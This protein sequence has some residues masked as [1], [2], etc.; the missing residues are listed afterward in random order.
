MQKEMIAWKQDLAILPKL[1]A[2]NAE[3]KA[4]LQ[5]A[6]DEI[7]SLTKNTISSVTPN[8]PQRQPQQPQQPQPPQT[9]Q[10]Q[11]QQQQHALMNIKH[12]QEQQ[13]KQYN[14]RTRE[15]VTFKVGDLVMRK[16]HAK[17]GSFPKERWTGPWKILE[18]KNKEGS[19]YKLARQA[20]P[21]R[22]TMA[23]IAVL[24][25]F[26]ERE[27]DVVPPKPSQFQSLEEAKDT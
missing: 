7:K 4:Q 2:E 15:I 9:P 18:V 23:N 6:R 13:E 3:L 20:T 16:N 24:R 14:K 1:R 22:T 12:A 26:Y 25:I 10:P 5:A 11:P 27:N 8:Q 17:I 21:N 19:A